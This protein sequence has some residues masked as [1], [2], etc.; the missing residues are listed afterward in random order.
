M[1]RF[2]LSFDYTSRH[3]KCVSGDQVV[4]RDSLEEAVEHIA[5]ERGLSSIHIRK[6]HFLGKPASESEVIDRHFTFAPSEAKAQ[7]A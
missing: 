2:H 3:D 5:R 1:P 6:R 7:V 4:I